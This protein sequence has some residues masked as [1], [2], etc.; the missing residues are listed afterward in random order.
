MKFIK[1]IAKIFLKEEMNELE[2]YKLKEQKEINENKIRN[3]YGNKYPKTNIFYTRTDKLGVINID[4]RQFLNWRNCLL[5]IV[6]G[7]IDD[8]KAFNSLNWVIDNIRYSPDSNIYRQNEY[9]AFNYETLDSKKGD[10]EDG[11]I[12][13]YC[14]MR[15]NGV[16]YWKIRCTTGNVLNPITKKEEG[17]AFLTYYVQ[18]LD[19][20]VILDWCFV[21]NQLHPLDRKPYKEENLYISTWFSFNEEFAYAKDV[22]DILKMNNTNPEVKK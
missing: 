1:E 16:P 15:Y 5:P 17:H 14:I 18:S 8:D 12:L 9:W 13:L 7:E 22:K 20:W 19:K 11:M 3:Y 21:P 10:C 4:V 6:K 2:T